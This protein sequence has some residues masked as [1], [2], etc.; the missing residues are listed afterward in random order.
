MIIVMA[1]GIATMCK[2]MCRWRNGRLSR[3]REE[4]RGELKMHTS[5]SSSLPI[6]P[7][8]AMVA[9]AVLVISQRW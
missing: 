6:G 3:S 2:M 5:N 9:P 8:A 4:P 1:H 7:A